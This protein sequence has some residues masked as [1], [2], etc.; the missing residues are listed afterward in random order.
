MQQYKEIHFVS[1]NWNP[2][3]EDQAI[4]R[5]HRIGQDSEVDVFRYE[6]DGFGISTKNIE[7]YSRGLQ[8]EKRD[9]AKDLDKVSP[10]THHPNPDNDDDETFVDNDTQTTI[11]GAT[12]AVLGI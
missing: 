1:P 11:D 5:S 6:M 4:A 8:D 12:R 3:V 7:K 9:I 2:A 10:E